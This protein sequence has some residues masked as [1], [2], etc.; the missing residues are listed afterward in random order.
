MK[1][2]T[3][4]VVKKD[5]TMDTIIESCLILMVL[6]LQKCA[7]TFLFLIV[8][9]QISSRDKILFQVCQLFPSEP[10]F[11]FPLYFFFVETVFQASSSLLPVELRRR[12]LHAKRIKCQS[13]EGLPVR[14]SWLG[15]NIPSNSPLPSTIFMTG[16]KIWSNLNQWQLWCAQPG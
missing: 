7:A 16:N 6:L 9:H 10:I 5:L 3:K 4:W 8:Q 12:R 1:L 2:W 15:I 11:S 13:W 14:A